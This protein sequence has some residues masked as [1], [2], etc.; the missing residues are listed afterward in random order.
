MWVGAEVG[1]DKRSWD[2]RAEGYKKRMQKRMGSVGRRY[3]SPV[4]RL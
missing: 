3:I 2:V 1:R 4:G